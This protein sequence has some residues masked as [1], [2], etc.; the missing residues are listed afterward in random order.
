MPRIL[1]ILLALGLAAPAAAAASD[2]LQTLKSSVDQVLVL[3]QDPRYADPNLHDEQRRRIWGLTRDSF[4]FDLIAKR[5]A[6][7]YHWENAFSAEQQR[8]FTDLFGEF[9]AG[10]Y[11]GRL[12]GQFSQLQVDYVGQEIAPSGRQAKVRTRVR[13]KDLETPIDYSMVERDGE[14]KVF[15]IFVEGISLAQNYQAQFRSLLERRT[16]AQVIEQLEEKIAEQKAAP[17]GG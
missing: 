14:W 1:C 13:Q 11:M 9:L 16:A 8:R 10:V 12:K 4:D 3:L 15:D 5:A 2:P 6:G 17:A 7:R